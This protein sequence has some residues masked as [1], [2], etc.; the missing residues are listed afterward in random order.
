MYIFDLHQDLSTVAAAT[1]EFKSKNRYVSYASKVVFN[2][3]IDSVYDSFGAH[4][5]VSAFF[6]T[7]LAQPYSYIK[8]FI[9]KY[10][11]TA[12]RRFAI[13]DL[14]FVSSEPLLKKVCALPIIY[15]SLTWNGANALAG[16]AGSG[17]GLSCIGRR[18]V[19]ALYASD[20][21]LD[22]AHLNERSFYDVLDMGECGKILNSHTALN[23]VFKHDRNLTD[24][25]VRLL[26]QRGGI[27]G[28]TPVAAFLSEGGNAVIDDYI[29]LIDTFCQK[30]G[31]QGAAIGTDFFGADPLEGL[32][33]Y[34]DFTKIQTALQNKGYKAH[35]INK[36]FFANAKTFFES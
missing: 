14:W 36:I 29:N 32:N 5:S 17:E 20:I 10:P 25:Q 11:P 27:V 23:S 8:T 22:T 31:T 6:T 9:E 16:G 35:D 34:N 15:A 18:T 12:L 3:F 28:L 24:K 33:T 19:R 21:A 26:L 7:R 30:F 13:E 4:T 1:V 2:S